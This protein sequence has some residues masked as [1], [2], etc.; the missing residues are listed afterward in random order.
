VNDHYQQVEQQ[1]RQNNS[2]RIGTII[3]VDY[4]SSSPRYQ[5]ADGSFVSG[6]ILSFTDRAGKNSQADFLEIGEQVGFMMM[7]SGDEIGYII[8]SLP[9]DAFP[10]PAQSAD[11]H[12]RK[13]DDGAIISYDREKHH[14]QINLPKAGTVSIK[15]AAGVT[16]T[17]DI[18]VN[19]DVIIDGISFKGHLHKNVVKGGDKSGTPSV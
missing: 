15:A 3:A 16:V 7:V 17:G 18:T 4:G 9:S 6:W 1:R 13:Y 12:V 19:G 2:L 8:G 10:A 11:L 5:V 14:Y